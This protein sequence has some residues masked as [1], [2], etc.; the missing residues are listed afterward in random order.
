VAVGDPSQAALGSWTF[1]PATD[2]DLATC[3]AIWR[4]SIN[5]YTH[6]LNLP[7][8]PDDL[9]A[10]LRLYAHLRSTDPDGFVVAERVDGTGSPRIVGF[11]AALRRGP[12]WFLSMLFVLPE[13]QGAGLGRALLDTVMPA[14]GTGSPGIASLATCTDSAQPISNALYAS[15][16]MAPRM[17]LLR[18][19]GL[20]DRPA[21]L[22]PL[23]GGIRAVR[24][25]EVGDVAGDRLGG[26]AL[27]SEI[28]GL[29]REVVGFDH[30]ED[31]GLV[32]REQRIG[33]L[34]LGPDGA[35]VGYGYASEAGRVGPVAV[36]DEELLGPVIGH[37][38]TTVRPRG[39]FGVWMPG[40]AGAATTS[41]LRAG[42]RIDGFPCLVCWDRPLTDFSRYIP[43]SPGLL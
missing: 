42:F 30:P 20:P 33:F 26:A 34:Y 7:E 9:G 2:Q 25:D 8:I 41:L 43:M 37:L 31:H 39:A 3:A 6:R 24:F 17:P 38:I 32:R 13:M 23:P 36:R 14:P 19:V 22:A 1:R 12:L 21:A 4:I 16:G 10:I 28:A 40:A 11:V 18:L 29:D 27:D 5:D 35:P 15:L